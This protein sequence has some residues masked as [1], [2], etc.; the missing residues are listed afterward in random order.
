MREGSLVMGI[1]SHSRI[2]SRIKCDKQV[3]LIPRICGIVKGAILPGYY[4]IEAG[5]SAVGDIF[6]WWVE[7]VCEGDASLHAKL[8]KEASAQRPGESGLIALDWNH[9]HRTIL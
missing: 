4:G 3:N 2:Y 9:A 8:T 1:I 6:N 7:V 5:Q